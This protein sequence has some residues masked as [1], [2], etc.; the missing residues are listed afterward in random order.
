MFGMKKP[1]YDQ[2]E[3][4]RMCANCNEELSF[5]FK[6]HYCDVCDVCGKVSVGTNN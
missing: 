6:Q 4:K 3:V 5:L 2:S 1:L